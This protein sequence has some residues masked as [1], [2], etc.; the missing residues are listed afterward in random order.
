[1]SN[2]EFLFPVSMFLSLGKFLHLIPPLP[3]HFPPPKKV[4]IKKTAWCR[5]DLI[6]VWLSCIASIPSGGHA[7]DEPPARTINMLTSGTGKQIPSV[8]SWLASLSCPLLSQETQNTRGPFSYYTKVLTLFPPSSPLSTCV[9]SKGNH[10]W[11]LIRA[12]ERLRNPQAQH[13]FGVYRYHSPCSV[14]S[15][16]LSWGIVNGTQ[17]EGCGHYS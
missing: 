6:R 14:S 12:G 1:M 5:H 2:T 16:I 4:K 15:N 13:S 10:D 3:T 11:A 17:S 9:S 8:F 7:G